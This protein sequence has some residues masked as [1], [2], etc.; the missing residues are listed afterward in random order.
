MSGPRPPLETIREYDARIAV[1]VSGQG[2][3]CQALIESELPVSVVVRTNQRIAARVTRVAQEWGVRQVKMHRAAYSRA[4]F[5]KHLLEELPPEDYDLIL[6]AGWRYVLGTEFVAAYP[7]R[8]LNIHPSLLPAH[9]G[10][11][12]PKVHQSVM[13]AGDRESGCTVHIVTD[14]LDAGPILGQARLDI[15]PEDTS[16][17]LALRVLAL[18]HELYPKVVKQY[19]AKLSP[20]GTAVTV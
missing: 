19:L 11:F 3:N 16:V 12:G 4:V 14:E 13:R 2:S 18:E 10:L 7:G 20:R 1:L 8:I 9:R 5:D 15:T 17:S 6:L